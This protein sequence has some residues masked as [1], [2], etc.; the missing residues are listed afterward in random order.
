M[1]LS[2]QNRKVSIII[3]T[4]NRA[5]YIIETVESIRRQTY[6]NW[7]LIIVD[8]GS[9]DNTDELVAALK[10]ERIQFHKAGRIGI[11][12]KIKNIGLKIAGGDFIAFND[13]DDLW[14]ETKLEKQLA[15]LDEY[16]EAGFSL[17]GGYNFRKLQEPLEYFYKQQNGI[18]YGNILVPLFRSEVS[19][20]TPSL[21]FRRKCLDIAG[22][23]NENETFS[24]SEFILSLATHFKAVVL[25]EPLFFRRIHSD[26][27]NSENWLDG[28]KQKIIIID[29]YKKEQL[30]PMDI[31]RQAA[32]HLYVNFGEDYLKRNNPKKAIGKFFRACLNK[33]WSIVPFKKS[34][35]AV[36]Q[37]FK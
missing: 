13:S 29:K 30:V 23:F 26:N 36:L 6:T 5:G 31:L 37:L 25:Y 15:A 20:L 4:Y 2:S 3:P 19:A 11:N 27:H 9:E 16:P 17:T 7:E 12:G 24:D 33:P 1:L 14:S 8:D 10:D 22:Y 32:F 18:N 21:L 34:V 28:Y 35:K